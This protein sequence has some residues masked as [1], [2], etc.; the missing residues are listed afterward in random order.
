MRSV[1]RLTGELKRI[2]EKEK[3]KKKIVPEDNK[4]T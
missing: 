4:N 2:I 1:D 3:P